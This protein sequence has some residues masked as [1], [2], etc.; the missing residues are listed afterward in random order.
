MAPHLSTASAASAPPQ[1]RPPAKPI[2]QTPKTRPAPD[3][4][5]HEGFLG[6]PALFRFG[7]AALVIAGIVFSLSMLPVGQWRIQKGLSVDYEKALNQAATAAANAQAGFGQTLARIR[8][9]AELAGRSPRQTP[10]DIR[11]LEATLTLP[12][13]VS[14]AAIISSAGE[15]VATAGEFPDGRRVAEDLLGDVQ[16][17]HLNA[18]AEVIRPAVTLRGRT[19]LPFG[20]ALSGGHAPA[21]A[22]FLIN[23]DA[24]V[25]GV[26]KEFADH[27]G[28]LR[29]ANGGQRV[30]ELLR[31]AGASRHASP[32]PASISTTAEGAL[33]QPLDYASTRL[34]AQ[35]TPPD[36]HGVTFTVGLTERFALIGA[37]E[38]VHA[39]WLIIFTADGIVLLLCGLTAWAI[40]QFARKEA[41]LRRLA[42]QDALTGLPN[43]RS[44]L[45][46]LDRAVER[47]KRKRRGV[48]LLMIDLDNFKFVNDS[49]G[50]VMGD[51]LLRRVA[52]VLLG[53]V[54]K[55]TAVCRLGGDE[56]TVII[57]N[58]TGP[59]EA[60]RTARA[61]L[62]RVKRLARIDGVAL[63]TWASI[64][65][66]VMPEQTST[67]E[68]LMQFADTAMYRAKALGKGQCVLYDAGMAQAALAQAELIQDLEAA[69][70]SGGLHLVYQPKFS[71][72]TGEVTG[73]EALVRWR[74]A[75][76]GMVPPSEFIPAAES[77]GLIIELGTWVLRAAI[78]QAR[79]WFDDDGRWRHVAVNVSAMQLCDETFTQ[80][81]KDALTEFRMPGACLQLE[82]TESAIARDVEGAK[83]LL[84]GVRRLGVTVAIDD[85]GTGYSSLGS[86]QQFEIDKLKLDMSFVSRIHTAGGAEVCQAVVKLGHALNMQVIA[87]GVETV[88][89]SHALS[90]MACDEV[91]GYLFARPLA[92]E[93]AEASGPAPWAL[94][95]PRQPDRHD[96][97]C[98]AAVS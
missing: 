11:R 3:Q 46:L 75:S 27:G 58:V 37:E 16:S 12:G 74:H 15:V 98:V 30:F 62:E 22:V 61:L 68:D 83:A 34:L 13:L 54:G 59:A 70:A 50:H 64:G 7:P 6:A 47:A 86:L 28:W 25:D 96:A 10:D 35:D 24:L 89:Q 73:F 84:A 8:H 91:Q 52:Q 45:S 19:A 9:A 63:R 94:F 97:A 56:F 42:T 5:D 90:L 39:T 33:A 78:R 17:R 31:T 80:I 71:M 4:L 36:A 93:E 49:A 92:A 60:E 87:E 66:A 67:A 29:I 79:S 23:E 76:R 82:I 26:K 65:I 41:Y 48:A 51:S 32:D 57:E 53:G 40:R 21:L 2:V 38:R 95:D 14:Y 77:S 18:G 55:D 85:F 20:V 43:R 44:F 72:R 88:E 81:V 69:I 1:L